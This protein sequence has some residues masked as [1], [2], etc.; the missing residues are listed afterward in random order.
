MS[1]AIT[2]LN[3]ILIMF[4]IILIGFICYKTKLIDQEGNKKI[5]NLLLMLVNPMLI[6][7]SYQMDYSKKLMIGLLIS[8]LLA[9]FTHIFGIFI[10]YIFVRG[11][12]NADV[13]IERFSSIY[14][15]CGF[16]GIPLIYGIFGSEGVFYITAYMTVFN[17]FI[18]THGLIMMIGKQDSKTMVKALLSPTIIAIVI[19]FF[20]FVLHIKLPNP[21]YKSL[22]YVASMNT[23]LAMLIAGI[24]IAQS[25]ILKVFLKKRIYLVI[26]LKQLLIPTVLLIIYSRVACSDAVMTTAVIAAAC[27]AATT[28]TLFALRYDK[29]ALYASEL[30]A[31]TTLFSIIT[32]PIV[33]T[34]TGF[35]LK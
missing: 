34:F 14:S 5:S 22:D 7:V 13:V 12:V 30:F 27:P 8:F 16:M 3:Q 28:G 25:D 10:S 23:P 35:I 19:G 2:T 9:I 17:L 20:L 4:L 33:M 15:N 31:M 24:T 32:I 26:F 29:N 18:W 1:L 6:L 21:I 11:K